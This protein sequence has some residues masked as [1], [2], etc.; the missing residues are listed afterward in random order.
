MKEEIVVNFR[1]VKNTAVLFH[2]K[3][4]LWASGI[5][6]LITS[7]LVISTISLKNICIAFAARS[8]A[9]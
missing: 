8:R 1:N 4:D 7:V 5:F 3:I 6:V 2:T 9:E